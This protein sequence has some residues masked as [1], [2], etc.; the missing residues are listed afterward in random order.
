[1]VLSTH[2]CFLEGDAGKDAGRLAVEAVV[3]AD[4]L[5]AVPPAVP[6][7]LET[8]GEAVDADTDDDAITLNLDC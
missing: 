4:V 8:D 7:I 3:A 2:T 5:F 6:G 1:M